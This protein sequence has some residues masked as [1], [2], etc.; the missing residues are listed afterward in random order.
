MNHLRIAAFCVLALLPASASQTAPNQ[1]APPAEERRFRYERQEVTVPDFAASGYVLD[2]GGGG[3]G[4]IG[5]LKPTQVVAIDLYKRELEEAP[6]GPLKIVMDATDLKFLDGSFH[7]AT[8]F[9]TLLYMKPADQEKAF[10]EIF[11]VLAPGGRFL[12][13]DVI[14]P[15]R[16]DSKKD[17]AVFP[18]LIT[19]PGKEVKTG[20]GTLFPPSAHDLDYFLRLA[21]KTGFQVQSKQSRDRN[22][23]VELRKPQ[24]V[25]APSGAAF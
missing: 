22:F 18:M 23:F 14:L 11:R 3:E 5:Q 24:A 12:L 6:P 21:E 19:L 20:Y 8:A 10:L 25:P 7:T 4:I 16:F 13:W 17:I 15:Q 2:I 1:P 9:F